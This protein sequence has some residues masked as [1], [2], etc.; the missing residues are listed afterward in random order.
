MNNEYPVHEFSKYIDSEFS[1]SNNVNQSNFNQNYMSK[2]DIV[3]RL[4]HMRVDGGI[5]LEPRLQEYIKKKKFHKENNIKPCINLEHQYQITSR[6][7]K[8]LKAFLR[9]K[10]DVY[11][12][13][14]LNKECKKGCGDKKYFPSRKFRKDKRIPKIRH[15]NINELPINRGMFVPDG[16]SSYYEDP[17]REIDPIMDARDFSNKDVSGFSIN[18]TRYDPRTDPYMDQGPEKYNKNSSQYRIDP[19]KYDDFNYGNVDNRNNYIISDLNSGIKECKNS[20]GFT[21]LNG[22][23]GNNAYSKY[24]S[25]ERAANFN[26]ITEKDRINIANDTRYGEFSKPSFSEKSTMDTD[27]KMVIPNISS[28]NKKNLNTSD[29]RMMSFLEPNTDNI[30]VNV[31]TAM[32][33]GMPQHTTKSYGYRNPHEHYYQ[34]DIGNQF[35]PEA[36]SNLAEPWCRGGDST[37]R[38]NKV[39]A[40]PYKRS[41]I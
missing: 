36:I 21:Q 20:V 27:N 11:K 33:R 1:F 17:I 35:G 24:D 8:I 6:D 5:M 30:D 10:T 25:F 9:G 15:E 32:I 41:V 38:D 3:D 16:T 28:N 7:K 22:N 23:N 18:D 12:K 14:D 40:R 29:Y 26:L 19:D 4:K 13:N 39:A 37:R 31:E 2:Y 34:Y